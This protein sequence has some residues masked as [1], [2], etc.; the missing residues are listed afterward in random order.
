[1]S[2]RYEVREISR[3]RQDFT[4]ASRASPV[5]RSRGDKSRARVLSPHVL[6]PSILIIK[7]TFRSHP[8]QRSKVLVKPG[9]S[10]TIRTIFNGSIFL[11]LRFRTKCY[12]YSFSFDISTGKKIHQSTHGPWHTSA[13]RP[14]YSPHFGGWQATCCVDNITRHPTNRMPV[15]LTSTLTL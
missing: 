10:I 1:M 11:K 4:A 2:V 7:A 6:Q 13:V 3:A 5:R 15:K 8:F 12:N 14:N 9:D